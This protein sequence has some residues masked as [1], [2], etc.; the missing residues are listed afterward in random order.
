MLSSLL[1]QIQGSLH[2]INFA[3]VTSTEEVCGFP[4][5]C[6]PGWISVIL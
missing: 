6:V 5:M 3:G 2:D 1:F 4:A